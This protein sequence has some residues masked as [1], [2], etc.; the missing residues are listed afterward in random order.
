MH[1]K[2]IQNGFLRTNNVKFLKKTYSFFLQNYR[3]ILM[4]GL[5]VIKKNNLSY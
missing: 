4:I 3:A 2:Y 1:I 5:L